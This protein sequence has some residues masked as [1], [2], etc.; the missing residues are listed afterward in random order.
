MIDIALCTNEGCPLK[1]ICYRSA[2]HHGKLDHQSVTR[3]HINDNSKCD[4]FIEKGY[5]NERPTRVQVGRRDPEGGPCVY[6]C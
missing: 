4:H 2:V 1:A 3:F 5:K 6:E